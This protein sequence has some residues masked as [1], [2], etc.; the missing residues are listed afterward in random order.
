MVLT[1]LLYLGLVRHP[2]SSMPNMYIC[3]WW[4]QASQLAPAK[5]GLKIY[6][7]RHGFS[8]SVSQRIY[9]SLDLTRR[10][11]VFLASLWTVLCTQEMWFQF[12]RGTERGKKKETDLPC[13]IL[14]KNQECAHKCLPLLEALE[15]MAPAN[16]QLQG[17]TQIG[18]RC[19]VR[20]PASRWAVAALSLGFPVG[21]SPI[22]TL[23]LP[24]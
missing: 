17:W 11:F 18:S 20:F 9:W 1:P 19:S 16:P 14:N 6:S 21:S 5:S 8:V 7:H 4:S 3:H 15:G 2:G 10:P 13:M 12:S 23:K 24:S 22:L